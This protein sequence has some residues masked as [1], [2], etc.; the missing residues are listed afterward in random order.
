MLLKIWLLIAGLYRRAALY[1]DA[2]V[3]IEEASSL[4]AKYET[5]LGLVTATPQS[6]RDGGHLTSEGI[7]AL[8][9][10]VLA[11]RGFLAQAQSL[12]EEGLDYFEQAVSRS[13]DHPR[14]TIGLCNILLD[15]ASR[16]AK[17]GHSSNHPTASASSISPPP[18]YP[19]PDDSHPPPRRPGLHSERTGPSSASVPPPPDPDPDPNPE[20]DLDRLAA[21]DRAYGLLSALVQLGTGWDSSEAWFA[22]ARIYEDNGQVDRARE[23]LWRCVE[24]EDARPVRHWRNV[25]IHGYVL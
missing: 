7:D 4:A 19:L 23:L 12:H 24:L 22:L 8:W 21:R 15:R 17:P 14:A 10:D 11:E 20:P 9:G 18:S 6:A 25:E 5:E 13:M 1:E 2:R 16:S 3:A